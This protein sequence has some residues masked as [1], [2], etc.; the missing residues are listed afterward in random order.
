[1][2]T[3]VFE[4]MVESEVHNLKDMFLLWYGKSRKITPE[5]DGNIC[6]IQLRNNNLLIF[7]SKYFLENFQK[8]K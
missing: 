7:S 4:K 6:L 3:K 2:A 5:I 8:N 1:M